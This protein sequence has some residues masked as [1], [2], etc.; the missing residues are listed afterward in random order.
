MAGAISHVQIAH[1]VRARRWIAMPPRIVISSTIT[2][3]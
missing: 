2:A 3:A 1:R